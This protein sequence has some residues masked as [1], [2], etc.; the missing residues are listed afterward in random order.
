MAINQF[1]PSKIQISAITNAVQAVVSFGEDHD[2]TPGE[3]VSFRVGRAFGM[4]EI[5]NQQ[6]KVLFHTNDTITIDIDTST[7]TAFTLANLNQAGTS[8]PICV[9]SASSA[10]PFEEN[11]SVNIED[12]FDNRRI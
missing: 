10:I 2:F 11:P 12:A 3:I 4:S 6:A 9:P 1:F 8:P 5:N 7:W